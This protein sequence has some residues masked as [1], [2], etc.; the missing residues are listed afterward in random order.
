M[1]LWPSLPLCV[2]DTFLLEDVAPL[3]I[4]HLELVADYGPIHGVGA[5]QQ[6]AVDDGV[7]AEVFW[8]VGRAAPVPAV[9][10]PFLGLHR[11]ILSHFDKQHFP[12]RITADQDHFPPGIPSRL[13]SLIWQ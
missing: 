10:M 12:I 7:G 11:T 2:S 3:A 4:P 8:Q 13:E 9:T 1:S 5:V 6:F